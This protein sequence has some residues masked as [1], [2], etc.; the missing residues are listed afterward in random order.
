MNIILFLSKK[1]LVG[2]ISIDN[3]I[4]R[5]KHFYPCSKFV[6]EFQV[7]YHYGKNNNILYFLKCWLIF[8]FT[9]ILLRNL[10][11][12]NEL[13]IKLKYYLYERE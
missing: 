11:Q 1:K 7:I 9:M 10:T 13:V 2:F 8:W 5:P 4:I 3:V 12:P 6:Y